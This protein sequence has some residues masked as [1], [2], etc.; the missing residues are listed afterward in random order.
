M[1]QVYLVNALIFCTILLVLALVVGAIQLILILVNVR[2]MTRELKEKF[3]ALANSVFG[4][5]VVGVK[6]GIEVMI[7]GKK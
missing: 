6:K 5:L 3:F 2:K 1:V 7:G 4:A